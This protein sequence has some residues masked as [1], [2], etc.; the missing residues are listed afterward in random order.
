MSKIDEI[1]E[2][3]R[4]VIHFSEHYYHQKVING[5]KHFNDIREAQAKA[6]VQIRTLIPKEEEIVEILRDGG[7][8][9]AIHRTMQSELGGEIKLRDRKRLAKAIHDTL[10]ALFDEGK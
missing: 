5:Q 7:R 6:K 10:K 3:F 9:I 1:L 4:K 8:Y 2:E